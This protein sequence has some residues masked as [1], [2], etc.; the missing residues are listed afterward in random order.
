M[1]RPKK[2]EEEEE[3]DRGLELELIGLRSLVERRL[4]RD[5]ACDELLYD[6]DTEMLL[7]LKGAIIR[8]LQDS[9][10]VRWSFEGSHRDD[11]AKRQCTIL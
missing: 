11:F 5:D 1:A 6:S 9:R 8:L 3:E 10:R 2:E 7:F 4:R